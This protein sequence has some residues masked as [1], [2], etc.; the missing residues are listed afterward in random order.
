MPTS[1]SFIYNFFFF[2]I[3]F[4]EFTSVQ[5]L[6]SVGILHSVTISFLFW[7]CLI[8]NKTTSFFNNLF[9]YTLLS[10]FFSF[11]LG[12]LS[13]GD[14]HATGNYALK[15]QV[16]VLKWVKKNIEAFGGD[17]KSITL[18]GYS[19]GA[20]SAQLHMFSPMSEGDLRKI[21]VYSIRFGSF[22][23]TFS[24]GYNYEL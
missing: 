20:V 17:S 16:V 23:R 19:A 6:N 12:F 18:L 14:K 2:Y 10:L 13:T 5:V 24:Q 21:F 3:L 4:L 15:D 8:R 7:V 11:I 9:S 22:F 1:L